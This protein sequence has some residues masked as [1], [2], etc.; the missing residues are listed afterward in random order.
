M[1]VIGRLDDGLQSDTS[2]P[3]LASG[4]LQ[5]PQLRQAGGCAIAG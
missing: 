1:L 4:P 2:E 3:C 5:F